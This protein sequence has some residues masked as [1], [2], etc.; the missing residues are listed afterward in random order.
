[1]LREPS[2]AIARLPKDLMVTMDNLVENNHNSS[3]SWVQVCAMK[4]AYIKGEY[5]LLLDWTHIL[6]LA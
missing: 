5:R 3:P 1:V 6:H 4:A 2:L